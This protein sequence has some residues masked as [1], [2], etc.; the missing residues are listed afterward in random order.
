MTQLATEHRAALLTKEALTRTVVIR[1][2]NGKR[3]DMSKLQG[4]WVDYGSENPAVM[5]P[6]IGVIV[7]SDGCFDSQYPDFERGLELVAEGRA[8]LKELEVSGG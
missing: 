3:Y 5:L 4:P 2:Y 6:G 7:W 8:K 1:E